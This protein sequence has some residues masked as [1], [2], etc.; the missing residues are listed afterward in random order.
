[1]C[2]CVFNN[3]FLTINSL[4]P[5]KIKKPVLTAQIEVLTGSEHTRR[6]IPEQ[7]NNDFLLYM[8]RGTTWKKSCLFYIAT[9]SNF[10]LL[11][12]LFL[13]F[14]QPFAKRETWLVGLCAGGK[15]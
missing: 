15:L 9:T 14:M 1:M 2:V 4:T 12:I 8:N 10:P 11:N 7:S 13:Y 5:L 6:F 3:N